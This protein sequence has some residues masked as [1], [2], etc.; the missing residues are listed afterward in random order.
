MRNEM[1]A[2]DHAGMHTTHSGSQQQIK[3]N[4]R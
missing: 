3:E 1:R 2:C 4:P